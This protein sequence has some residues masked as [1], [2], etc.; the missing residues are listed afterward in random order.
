MA[1]TVLFVIGFIAN[2]HIH[3]NK[4]LAS[5]DKQLEGLKIKMG[6]L[7]KVDLEY[8]TLKKYMEILDRIDEIHPTKLPMLIELSR[9]I[10]KDTWLKKIQFKKGKMKIN[11]ISSSAS[12]LVPIVENSNYFRE[13]RFVGTII[14]DSKGEKFTISSAIGLPQ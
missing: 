1:A 13:T 9:I 8:E 14:T 11:G 2:Y 5:L 12:R 4:I 7:E 3:N 6:P 10:P